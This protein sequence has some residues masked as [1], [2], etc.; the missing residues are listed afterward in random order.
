MKNEKKII[1]NPWE[2]EDGSIKSTEEIQSLC[3][4]W[5]METWEQYLKTIEV[6][7]RERPLAEGRFV[8]QVSQDQYANLFVKLMG[9][10]DY[11]ETARV[12]RAALDILPQ[13][14][15]SIIFSIYW[16]EKSISQIAEERS[17]A[18]K[19]IRVQR[20]LAL[21]KLADVLLSGAVEKTIT[22]SKKM[23]AKSR[24]SH[25]PCVPP[26]SLSEKSNFSN[27]GGQL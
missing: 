6:N 8:D 23:R 21:K 7:Q 5:D 13:E 25:S 18:R 1:L 12:A 4:R 20:D 14:Q 15:R 9:Q 11:P 2:N 19:T 16:E 17:Q 27:K 3:K 22:T 24:S 10:D 26:S